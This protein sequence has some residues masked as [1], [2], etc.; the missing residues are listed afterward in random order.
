MKPKHESSNDDDNDDKK[1]KPHHKGGC[2][3]NKVEEKKVKD[4]ISK[5]IPNRYIIVFKRG[6]PQ[7][8]IDFHKENVQ[9]STTFNP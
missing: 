7:E 6:A 1:K 8:E 3:E 5:I 9:Q 2:H 4:A